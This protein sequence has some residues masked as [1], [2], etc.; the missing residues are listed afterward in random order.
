MSKD[1]KKIKPLTIFYSAAVLILA[2][3]AAA[4]ASVYIFGTDNRFSRAAV[5]IIPFP[6][7][8]ADGKMISVSE[9]KEN[10]A[11]VK[12]FYE[13]Q[14]FA[15]IGMRVDFTTAEG[16]KRLM[17]REK[18]LLH[19]MIENAAVC[20]LA[21]KRGIKITSA[22]VDQSVKRKLD[23][24]GSEA[25]VREE[26]E[27]LYGWSIDDF[28]NKI[29]KPSLCA[30]ELKKSVEEE[31]KEEFESGAA[32]KAEKARAELAAGGDFSEIAKKYSDGQ[33]GQ[34]GGEIGW[35]RRGQIMPEIEDSVFQLNAGDASGILE[36]EIGYHIVKLDDKRTEEGSELIKIKQ[37][38]C[39][40]II[41]TDW[42]EEEMKKMRIYIPM[43]EYSWNE[44]EAGVD[45]T[46]PDM[47]EFEK[48]LE[49]TLEQWQSIF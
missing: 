9:L 4:A 5:K 40:K 49:E 7:A 30:S 27:R 22:Q 2:S 26:L 23:E 34:A 41:F 20:R 24:Y 36:S 15:S 11:S 25:R 37:I 31:K 3:V 19:K 42:L 47:I 32:A 6:A 21:D 43:K 16:K 38:F 45:F 44:D 48:N 1:I 13:N 12:S 46:S 8:V 10:T 39:G 28:K 17:A 29:V 35:I 18:W 14:D 33:S